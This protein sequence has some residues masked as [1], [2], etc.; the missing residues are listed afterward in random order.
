MCVT[1]H[2]SLL[3]AQKSILNRGHHSCL[4]GKTGS[5]QDPPSNRITPR[6]K[7]KLSRISTNSGSDPLSCDL[8][9]GQPFVLL[10]ALLVMAMEL[11]QSAS[12]KFL[13]MSRVAL[14]HDRAPRESILDLLEIVGPELHIRSSDIFFKP[15]QL[16]RAGDRHDPR[17]PCQKPGQRDLRRSCLLLRC[18]LRK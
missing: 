2:A 9:F 1:S 6:Q 12:D 14:A 10:C 4:C 5:L 7:A 13:Q 3:A 16:G 11:L 17:S 18:N 8:W 15:V